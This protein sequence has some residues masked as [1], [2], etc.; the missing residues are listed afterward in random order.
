MST[1]LER[2]AKPS[3][4]LIPSREERAH[5]KAVQRVVRET[6]LQGLK[7]DADAALA[8]RIMERAV[9]LDNH[10]KALA[11]GDPIL[12]AILSRIELSFVDQAQRLQRNLGSEFGL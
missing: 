11:N 6:Q 5:G 1:E 12:D 10:R 7:V 2:W 8:G 4:S 9:D 3:S